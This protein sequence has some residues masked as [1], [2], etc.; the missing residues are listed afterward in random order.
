MKNCRKNLKGDLK[1]SGGGDRR[2]RIKLIG[3]NTKK[4]TPGR[5][6]TRLEKFQI[7]LEINPDGLVKS[8]ILD[9]AINPCVS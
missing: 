2:K 5:F 6:S 7:N 1:T 4:K 9:G 8:L 3:F